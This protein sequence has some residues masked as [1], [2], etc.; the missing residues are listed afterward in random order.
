MNQESKPRKVVGEQ[1]MV[2]QI[3][4]MKPVAQVFLLVWILAFSASAAW[5]KS[6]VERLTSEIQR[7]HPGWTID[8]SLEL[9]NR[10]TSA[11]LFTETLVGDMGRTHVQIV[12]ETVLVNGKDIS[13][14]L[15][16]RTANVI[17]SPGAQASAGDG[18]P[19]IQVG[20]QRNQ[21]V[22]QSVSN[23]TNT[24]MNSGDGT[25]I[26]STT[27]SF[28]IPSGLIGTAI[29]ALGTFLASKRS[30]P[31]SDGSRVRKKPNPPAGD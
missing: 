25:H 8:D 5:M 14:N 20:D 21:Q 23:S 22:A 15:G 12:N 24:Q 1:S 17:N 10:S 9:L 3:S 7:T 19:N 30:K 13:G 28:D 6:L 2:I 31:Q 29:G 4:L 27:W 26:E 18:S 11:G 16:S